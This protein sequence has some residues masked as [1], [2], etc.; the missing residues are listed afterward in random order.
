[1][2]AP[3]RF[4][5]LA[6]ATVI[7]LASGLAVAPSAAGAQNRPTW[8]AGDFWIYTRTAGSETSTVRVDV[9]ARESLT[10]TSGTYIVW[11]TTTTVTPAT[12]N[13]TVTHAWIQDSNLGLAKANFTV[14]LFGDV[15]VTFDPP[16]AQAVFP[17]AVNAQWSL[18]AT[19]RLVDFAFSFALP[20]SG[21]VI[22]EQDTAVPAG[23]FRV[24]VIRT[25][26]TGSAHDRNYYSE[27]AGNYARQ[28]S[29]DAS[30]N[31]VANQEL[32]SYRYQSANFFTLIIVGLGVLA[33]V[34]VVA[35]LWKKRKDAVGQ[36][37]GPPPPPPP[38]P[39]S[40]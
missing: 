5:A 4:L 35:Y 7:A 3:P 24:A 30:G 37:G 14:V 2:R 29:Y 27:G 38:R 34:V 18:S 20:Y 21:T 16:L 9:F 6:L 40:P 12:G 39:E 31:R 8:T 19:V 26:S 10:L 1:M 23:T 33:A 32:T 11:H 15:Q 25:P 28:E 36:P 17:L 22:A 13:A